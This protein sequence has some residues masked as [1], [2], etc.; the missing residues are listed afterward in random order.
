MILI[1]ENGKLGNQLFQYHGLKAYFPKQKLVFLGF[2]ELKQLFERIDST[3][4]SRERFIKFF[5]LQLTSKILFFLADIRLIGLITESTKSVSYA[6][7][8]RNGLLPNIYL[9]KGFFQHKDA[10]S[11]ISV[12][13]TLK[14]D[15]VTTAHNW[16]VSK[17]IHAAEKELVFVHIRR[18]DY[19]FWPSRD[20]PAV[21]SIKWYKRVIEQI[22]KT[23]DNPVFILMSDDQYYLFD[24]FEESDSLVISN[25]SAAVDIAI[26]SICTHGVMSASTFAWW[27]AYMAKHRQVRSKNPIFIAPKYWGGHR[28]NVWHPPNFISS[29]LTY[30]D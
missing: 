3:F 11:I 22:R 2:D 24:L 23:I 30:V 20:Y 6:I 15:L 8:K 29:W 7:N 27:G 4:I 26:M 19:F 25:N 28:K 5:T 9:F 13:P 14:P 21:L 17:G 18:G 10:I 16:L 1:P 12:I